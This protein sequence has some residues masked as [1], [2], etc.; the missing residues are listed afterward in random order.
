MTHDKDSQ[1]YQSILAALNERELTGW[2]RE[3][4]WE[5]LERNPDL[6]ADFSDHCFVGSQI[7]SIT[8]EQLV[9]SGIEPPLRNVVSMPLRETSSHL[10]LRW[11]IA[12]G[13]AALVAFLAVVM[14]QHDKAAPPGPID[15]AA[16]ELA[17]PV[18]E[19]SAPA[20][21]PVRETNLSLDD[22][23]DEAVALSGSAALANSRNPRG[24]KPEGAASVPDK[25]SFNH[26]VRPILSENCFYCHGPDE[27]TQEAGLRLDLRE[28]ATEDLG[29]YAAIVPGDAES[30][31]IWHRI[32]SDDPTELMPPP[33]SHRTLNAADREILRRW[34]NDGA[35]YEAHWAFIKPKRS[36]VPELNDSRVKNPIDAFILHRLRKEGLEPN[37]G[38]APHTLLRRL[39]L[40]LIGLPPTLEELSAFELHFHDNPDKAVEEAVDRL[41][42]SPHFG[43][44]MALP[45]LDAARY[46]DSNGFQQDGNRH[47]WPWRDWVIDA[48][49][50]NMPFDQF[51]LEQ[52]AGDLLEN[53][54]QSQIIA[55]AFNRNHML[56]GEGGAIKEEQRI[57]YV[58]DRVDTT[59]TT[60]LGLT[61]ACAQCHTHKYDPITHQE[62]FQF[63]AFFNNVPETG[64]VD[65]RS[66]KGCAFGSSSTVQLSRPL[67]TLPTVA[68]RNRQQELNE[69]IKA[70][71]AII[72]QLLPEVDPLRRE[73]EKSFTLAQL[74]DRTRFRG[75]VSVY[76]RTKENERNAIQKR[77]ITE[78]YLHKGNHGNEHWTTVGA[79]IF[80][81]RND[82]RVTTESII[83]VMVMGENPPGKS[84]ETFI[85]DRGDYQQ[86]TE[87]VNPGTP[88]FLPPMK[89]S[90]PGNRLGLAQWLINGENPLTA[91]VTV[92]RLWAQ[93]FGVGIVKTSEDFGVQGELPVHPELIDWLAVEFVE[94]GWDMKHLIRLIVT[95]ST[96][97]QS[98]TF[99]PE[100]LERDPE[101]RLVGRGARSR[102][103]AMLLRDQALAVAG[104]L[105]KDIG[106]LPVYPH[107]PEGLWKDFSFGKISYPHTGSEEQLYR[108]SLYTFWR[109]TSAPPNMFDS[110]S[111]QV[112]SVK[113]STTNT[114][115]HALTLLNDQT[116]VEAARALAQ[117][118]MLEGGESTEDRLEFAFHLAT[119]RLPDEREH[120]LLMNGFDRSLN[121][122]GS[123]ESEAAEYAAAPNARSVVERAALTRMAQVILNLDE[124]LNR[125]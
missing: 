41:L 64:G 39:S 15:L 10:S 113:T 56:N 37:P 101:N 42:D 77:D 103:P 96:Y 55:T 52:I 45:W 121:E 63:F 89:D 69:K 33:E 74:V 98:S 76:L 24:G 106:G 36:E 11:P 7:R 31:E 123:F 125:P 95:S 92:N 118:M 50:D 78:F 17:T 104:L 30:S 1:D 119:G 8:D 109:R 14:M 40:D 122:F 68:Q 67:L 47:Q 112:C 4:L 57:N 97:C 5:L 49:N 110:S 82:L 94:S 73:W 34:I 100:K 26:H 117:R 12:V 70:Q 6:I 46:A 107:Q 90:A 3:R 20:T 51:T 19:T 102:L 87:Q 124:T 116:Y 79:E 21:T 9:A 84:R 32:L 35:K 48:Y 86:P 60:W 85:L 44:R 83:E 43:E 58:V 62:Y 81:L 16:T 72:Q 27:N 99:T 25:I 54:T 18:S 65:K 120:Q 108:R 13:I 91:R 105:R 61:M 2:E 23:N 59:A 88:S 66:G 93:F 22:P 38:A 53:P 28:S 111:R 114:P 115:L 80:K 75:N 29:G 71:E